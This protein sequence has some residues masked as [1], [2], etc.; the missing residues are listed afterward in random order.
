[1]LEEALVAVADTVRAVAVR[2]QSPAVDSRPPS[3]TSARLS[4]AMAPLTA[5]EMV[6]VPPESNRVSR[7]HSN[8]RD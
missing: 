4:A 1:M 7:K 5:N 6:F 8:V 3:L 2:S